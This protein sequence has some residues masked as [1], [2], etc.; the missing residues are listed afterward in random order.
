MDFAIQAALNT[1]V[2]HVGDVAELTLTAAHPAGARF[3]LPRLD[4]EHEIVVREQ[5]LET[6]P[7]AEGRQLSRAR[8]RITSLALGEHT[9]ST[10]EVVFVLGDG[11]RHVEN[12]PELAF[13]VDSVLTNEN[14]EL[15]GIKGPADWPAAFPPWIVPLLAVAVLA[16]ALGLV[17][18]R[19]MTRPRTIL[20][21]PPSEPPYEIALR[22]LRRLLEKGWIEQGQVE[23]FY[24]ELT[25]IARRY[26][27]GRFGLRAPERTTEEFIREASGSGL[28]KADHQAL[29]RD[30][31]EQS[32]LVKFARFTPGADEMKSAY[33]SAEKLVLETCPV[34]AA[35]EGAV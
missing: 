33:V 18:A 30:F 26:I 22:A 11:T 19:V 13:R 32:D 2:L 5:R 9:V 3:E 8:Y 12:F 16:L 29:V 25:G 23:P 15:H 35:G 17:T 7:L 31:L 14:A 24:V 4:R 1:N 10:G 20:H 21:Y 28:L 27:E 34:E 6:R